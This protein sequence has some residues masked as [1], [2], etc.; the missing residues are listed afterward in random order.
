ME[1]EITIRPLKLNLVPKLLCNCLIE[2][3][4]GTGKT[5]SIANI[6][7]HAILSGQSVEEIL[8]VTFTEDATK[9]LHD[10]IRRNINN[11]L[12]VIKG[13]KVDTA[14]MEILSNYSNDQSEKRLDTAISEMDKT[15]IF[16][17]HGFCNRILKENAF[18]SSMAFGLELLSDTKEL[19]EEVITDQWRKLV[20]EKLSK[21]NF[22]EASLVE[23]DKENILFDDLVNYS[24]AFLS[25]PGKILTNDETNRL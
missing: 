3:S 11:A 1:Q 8:V 14:L 23:E 10:R 22:L 5:Y 6:Y 19:L 2:A 24:K 7:L 21:T 12:M 17:I 20:V 4:A 9:E 18:E 13:V 15:S 25:T 16:T